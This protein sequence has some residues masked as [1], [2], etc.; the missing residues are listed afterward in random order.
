MHF[1]E[2]IFTN[3]KQVFFEKF[4]TSSQF[5]HDCCLSVLHRCKSSTAA[6]C[7]TLLFRMA[8]VGQPV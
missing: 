7:D 5:L 4:A 2:N 6:V 8:S 1:V 3:T